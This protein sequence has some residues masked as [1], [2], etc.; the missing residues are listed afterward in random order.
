MEVLNKS[1]VESLLFPLRDRLGNIL[2]L[3]SITNLRFD[4]KKKSD[5]SVVQA[6]IGASFDVDFPMTAI[7]VIDTTLAAYVAGYEYKLY[8]KGTAGSENFVLGP[9]FFRVEDD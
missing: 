9:E 8:L 6:D 5:N 3:A 4:T 2:T 7:C 1:T